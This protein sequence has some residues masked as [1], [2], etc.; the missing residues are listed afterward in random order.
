MLFFA[1]NKMPEQIVLKIMAVLKISLY[2]I[3]LK[4]LHHQN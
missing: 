3:A 1:D 4:N 2:K